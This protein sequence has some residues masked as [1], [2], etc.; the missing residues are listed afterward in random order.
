MERLSNVALSSIAVNGSASF[1]SATGGAGASN[2]L[3]ETIFKTNVESAFTNTI[4]TTGA[5]DT[6]FDFEAPS[7]QYMTQ[8][9]LS[10]QDE[11]DDAGIVTSVIPKTSTYGTLAGIT[12][13]GLILLRRR[14]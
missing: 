7:G 3:K 11:F 2:V 10:V 4:F 12:A 6:F 5:Q 9:T 1:A 13:L 8:I 14:A